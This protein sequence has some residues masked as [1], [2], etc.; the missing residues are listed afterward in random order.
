MIIPGIKIPWQV[1]ACAG[2]VLVLGISG[3]KLYDLGQDHKQDEWDESIARGK[4]IVEQLKAKQ[5]TVT[6]KVVT[7]TVE[8]IKIVKEKGDTIV[9][10]VE[11]LI[12][13]S[14]PDMPGGFR[15]LHDAAAANTVPD[16]TEG[17]NA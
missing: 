17:T 12:P 11:V 9:K 14:T 6:T 10:R 16:S 3:W 5:G 15:V 2:V 7:E 13:A 8:R 4:V 1:F